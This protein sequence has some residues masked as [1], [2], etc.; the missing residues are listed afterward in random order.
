M[1]QPTKPTTT[2]NSTGSFAS[3]FAMGAVVGV[4]GYLVYG[5]SRGKD[6]KTN[7]QKEFDRIR[8]MLYQEGVIETQNASLLSIIAAV[9]THAQ[10]LLDGMPQ[11][12]RSYAKKSNKKFKGV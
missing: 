11:K 12:K 4:I 1:S 8:D 6:L 5:T 7:F 3:G 9:Q 2:T 10:A